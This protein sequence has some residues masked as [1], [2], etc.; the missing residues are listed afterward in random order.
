MC[1]RS[2]CW[3]WFRTFPNAFNCGGVSS[4][5]ANNCGP[6]SSL[7]HPDQCQLPVSLKIHL[8]DK[9]CFQSSLLAQIRHTAIQLGPIRKRQKSDHKGL[10]R[11]AVFANENPNI[12][13]S[14]RNRER[15]R[16]TE[17]NHPVLWCFDRRCVWCRLCI[18]RRCAVEKEPNQA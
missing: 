10:A 5:W 17:T 6:P 3:V 2:Q 11:L 15:A 12:N 8:P 14:S 16:G 13:T 1:I 18:R 4:L 7:R 9:L